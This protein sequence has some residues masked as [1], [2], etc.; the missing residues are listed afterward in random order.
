MAD[1]KHTDGI[2]YDWAA[3]KNVPVTPNVAKNLAIDNGSGLTGC[4]ACR[5]RKLQHICKFSW[6]KADGF[7]AYIKFDD[8]CDNHKAQYDIKENPI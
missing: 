3:T 6:M 1:T 5:D 8:Y 4:S 2:L 7:C